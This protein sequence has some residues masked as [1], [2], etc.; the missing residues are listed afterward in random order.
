MVDRAPQYVTSQVTTALNETK[1]ASQSDGSLIL[2][3]GILDA[4]TPMSFASTAIPRG[5][6]YAQCEVLDAAGNVVAVV[7]RG[8]LQTSGG[9]VAGV[10]SSPG[11]VV[12]QGWKLRAAVTQTGQ[13][14]ATS[15][16]FVGRVTSVLREGGF[17]HDEEPGSGHGE[18]RVVAQTNPAAGAEFA[19][20]TVPVKCRWRVR[21]QAFQLV[22]D[23]NVATRVPTL[24]VMDASSQ[25]VART[26]G[27]G[28]AASL[29]YLH[30]LSAQVGAAA[31]AG[32]LAQGPLP[33]IHMPEGFILRFYCLNIQAGDQLSSGRI[34]VEEWA[35]P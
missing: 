30:S 23:A 29:S 1:R 33:D 17:I 15:V 34:G 27:S 35:V 16:G 24:A 25:V 9:A 20:Q 10:S 14:A 13:G 21:G 18:V 4:V 12:E 26:F 3:A 6:M 5:R 7:W 2:S 8:Y 22:T 31:L 32:T 11:M 28:Q 19:N